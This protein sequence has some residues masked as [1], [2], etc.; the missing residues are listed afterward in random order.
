[1]EILTLGVLEVRK[2]TRVVEPRALGGRKPKQILEVLALA[3][4]RPVRKE[5]LAERLWGDQSPRAPMAA[6]ENHVWVLRQHLVDGLGAGAGSVVVAGPGT[7][8]L[9]LEALS[10][11]LDRFDL[12]VQAA[13]D[14]GP[15][16]SRTSLEQALA[17]VRGELFEDEPYAEWAAP[18]REAYRTK[19]V[20]ARLALAEAALVA[21]DPEAALEHT[22]L[23]LE[24]EP[25]SERAC[26]L[27]LEAF[28]RRG[29][30]QGALRFFDAFRR[31]L[32]QELGLEPLPET[33]AVHEAVRYGTPRPEMVG[34]RS[35]TGVQPGYATLST[36]R[37]VMPVPG[38]RTFMP[39]A[40]QESLG[41]GRA[42]SQPM[43]AIGPSELPLVGRT[44]EVR[45]LVDELRTAV[46]GRFALVLVEGLAH[47]GKSRL[48]REA[49]AGMGD[50]LSGWSQYVVPYSSLSYLPLLSAL[51]AAIGAPIEALEGGESPEGPLAALAERVRRH[52][53]VVFVLD[54][55]HHAEL[56]DIRAISALHLRC[57]DAS[58]VIVGV[59]RS[60]EVPYH[61]A[62]RSLPWTAH[63]RV[64][65]LPPEQFASVDGAGAFSRT[66][67]YGAYLPAWVAGRR[68][69]PPTG[70]E[71]DAVLGRCQA[72]G[73]R[74]YRIL[75]TASALNEPLSLASVAAAVDTEIH[76]VAEELDVL[77]ARGLLR[78][79]GASGFAFSSTLVADALRSQLS[80]E[81]Q[82]L[83]RMVSTPWPSLRSMSEGWAN[84]ARL[85]P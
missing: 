40:K 31:E 3:R 75:L 19:V 30:R 21:D 51:G 72:A 16:A 78:D 83:I 26:R 49:L 53:P 55:L 65:P 12:L 80:T 23:A 25:F 27:K 63:L 43:P 84:P 28:V 5:A 14:A 52:A 56:H 73:P 10:L 68:T 85:K 9:A 33:L 81:R 15:A 61:H 6:L 74:A 7:Y 38:R 76:D 29:E 42:L 22:G 66:G 37:R 45:F 8:R 44:D 46:Q 47:V 18:L 54:D 11:D 1:M 79:V 59:C 41:T 24:S 70:D 4:G 62:L 36:L 2:R 60:E 64:D 58:A 17:L 82:R 34:A 71:R 50:V 32:K 57:A 77:V 13:K 48:V 39:P 67:G 69:G 20:N 35:R